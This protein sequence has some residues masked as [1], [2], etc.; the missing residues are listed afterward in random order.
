MGSIKL[1]VFMKKVI[2]LLILGM[3]TS[4]WAAGEYAGRLIRKVGKVEVFLNPSK[5]VQGKGLT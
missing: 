3:S 4:V 2:L 5:S 1:E